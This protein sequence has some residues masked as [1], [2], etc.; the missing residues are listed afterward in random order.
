MLYLAGYAVYAVTGGVL[1][2]YCVVK[3]TRLKPGLNDPVL[4]V[5]LTRYGL[6]RHLPDTFYQELQEWDN[7]AGGACTSASTDR[8]W[9]GCEAV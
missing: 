9:Q 3:L 8:N 7:Q 2:F 4:T 5:L 6:G 1:T